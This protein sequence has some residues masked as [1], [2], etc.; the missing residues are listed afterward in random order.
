VLTIDLSGRR[1]LVTGGARGIG[2]G[3][4]RALARCGADVAFTYL[5]SERGER[6]AHSLVDEVAGLGR[7]TFCLTAAADNV[8]AMGAAVAAAAGALGG[9]DIVV[10][11]VGLN[12]EASL[13]MLHLAGWQRALDLNL[14][15]SFIAVKATLP[16]LL[17]AGRGAIILIGSSAVVDGGGGARITQQPRPVW[18]A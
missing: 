4:V 18:R 9:L 3:I 17:Q 16:W 2:A 1:A 11:N 6:A 12:W 14:T 7:R 10:P 15:A 5:G 8:Q 13:D